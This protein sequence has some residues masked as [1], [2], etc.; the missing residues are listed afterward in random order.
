[1]KTK[2]LFMICCL[3]SFLG[4]KSQSFKEINSNNIFSYISKA[5]VDMQT[6]QS[7]NNIIQ[8]GNNNLIEATLINDQLISVQL[9]NNNQTTYK[10]YNSSQSAGMLI[11]S[12]GDNNQ[13]VV[14]GS[15]SISNN[16]SVEVI[17]NNKTIFIENR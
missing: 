17:G 15:N 4:V 1:M 11:Q 3:S 13:I 6:N 9:G 14:D 12:I 5:S 2:F 8:I 7:A 10:D 16:M